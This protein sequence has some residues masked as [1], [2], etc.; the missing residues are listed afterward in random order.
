MDFLTIFGI[1]LAFIAIAIGQTIEGG[2]LSHLVNG[3]AFLIV[4]GGSFGAVILQTPSKIFFRSL[5]IIKWMVLP[6]KSNLLKNVKRIVE[7]STVTRKEGILSIESEI[8]KEKDSFIRKGLELIIDGN[9]ASEVR[10]ALMFEL[11]SEQHLDIEAT[12]VFESLGGYSP[13]IGILGT[14]LGLIHVMDNLSDPTELGAGIAVAFVATIYGVGFA[15]LIFL[16]IAHKLRA[17]VDRRTRTREMFIEG[18]SAIAEGEH[19]RLIE[20][21]LRGFVGEK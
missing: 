13:T 1:L 4:I 17:H 10:S 2:D 6:P 12:G 14:V 20:N 8:P 5:K 7:I 18:F 16:P 11:Q 19:P 21:R 3:S 15:N 9:T